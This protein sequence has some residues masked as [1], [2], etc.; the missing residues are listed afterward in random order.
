LFFFWYEKEKWL[1]V[2][3]DMEVSGEVTVVTVTDLEVVVME[4]DSDVVLGEVMVTDLDAVLEVTDL[5]VAL[6]VT[7]VSGEDMDAL[8]M[9]QPH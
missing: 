1:A 4:L 5:D 8:L 7:E 9:F 3:L 6:E 2:D